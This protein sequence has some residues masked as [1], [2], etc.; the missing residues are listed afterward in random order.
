MRRSGFG[1]SCTPGRRALAPAGRRLHEHQPGRR[2]TGGARSRCRVRQILCRTAES[3]WLG[4][5]G[6]VAQWAKPGA[7]RALE[8]AQ[9]G[10]DDFLGGLGGVQVF[11]LG[12]GMPLAFLDFTQ[13]PGFFDIH[14]R[15]LEHMM[16]RVA[17]FQFLQ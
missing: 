11:H 10:L 7:G 8:T 13:R 6:V 14:H 12:V 16:Q 17:G 3:E 9:E 1:I 15:G 2:G 5:T 4:K